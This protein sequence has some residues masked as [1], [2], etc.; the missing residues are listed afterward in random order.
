MSAGA[1]FGGKSRLH[2]VEEKAKVS[3]GILRRKATTHAVGRLR[4]MVSVIM[5]LQQQRSIGYIVSIDVRM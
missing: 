4:V 2:F 1:Y 5:Q 3:G